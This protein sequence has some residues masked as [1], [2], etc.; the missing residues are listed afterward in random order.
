MSIIDMLNDDNI[1]LEYLDYKKKQV[2]MSKFEIKRLEDYIINKEYKNIVNKIINNNYCFSIPFKHLINK[3]NKEKKRVVYTFNNDENM[4]L[5]II[6][7]LFTKEYDYI[8]SDN[9]YSFRR[10]KGIKNA[11]RKIINYKGIH[12]LYGYKI[13]ISNYFNSI[14]IDIMISLFKE[15]VNDEKL[16]KYISDLLMNNKVLFN[17]Q[18]IEEKKGIM[19][20]TPIAAFLSNIYLKELDEYFKKNNILYFR[21]ADDIIFFAEKD[22]FEIYVDKLNKYICNYKLSINSDKVQIIKP[23][24]RFDFLG[25]GFEKNNIDISKISLKKIKGKIKR[26]SKK[27]R[28]WKTN[29][30]VDNEKAMKV[31]IKKY[32]RK[33]FQIEN[34]DGLTWTLWYF[35]IINVTNSLKIIDNYLQQSIRYIS[36]G[37][38][39]KKNY[40]I[41]YTKL[42][43][44][45]YKTLV[46]E[47]Y[48]YK[49]NIL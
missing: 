23:K 19:A 48:N 46:N 7:Y 29:K 6:T 31:M 42:K 39:N 20:G 40:N 18:I 43:E 10:N 33:F 12:K 8:Y 47:Y 38:Y 5:K 36:T 17:N 22:K 14:D 2:S 4:V 1:W 49:N 21:Y 26:S 30:N 16:V 15:Y 27:I 24:D 32:N 13:D 3:I 37:K 35:P 11:I 34:K 41:R 9:C 28:R 44:L 25:F 45:G